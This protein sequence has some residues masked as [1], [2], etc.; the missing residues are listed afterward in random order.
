MLPPISEVAGWPMASAYLKRSEARRWPGFFISAGLTPPAST[1]D[2]P[3]VMALSSPPDVWL[4][5]AISRHGLPPGLTYVDTTACG[6]KWVTFTEMRTL[7]P[8]GVQ[9]SQ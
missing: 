2:S 9:N 3:R 1:P 6:I 7:Q 8:N 5:G 4:T